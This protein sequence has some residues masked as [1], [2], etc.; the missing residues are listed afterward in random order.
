MIGFRAEYA[1]GEIHP[2]GEEVLASRWFD[3][4]NLPEIPR[5]GSIARAMLDDWSAGLI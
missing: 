4:G 1:E 2:D 5:K 3:R